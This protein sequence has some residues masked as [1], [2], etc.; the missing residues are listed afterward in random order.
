MVTLSSADN[1]LKSFYLDAMTESLNTKTNPFLAKIERT[2]KYVTG[3]EVCKTMRVGINAGIGA[4][5][6]TGD[7]PAARD[8]QYIQLRTGLKNLYGTIEI[9]DKAIRASA[10]NEGAFVNL[11]NDEME[12]LIKSATFNFG[13]MLFGSG[14]GVLG[15]VSLTFPSG[16]KVTNVQNFATGMY[17]DFVDA[18]EEFQNVRV[19][20]MDYENDALYFKDLDIDEDIIDAELVIHGSQD[21][22]LTGLE[23]IFHASKLYGLSREESYMKPYYSEDF[24]DFTEEK[25]EQVIDA[26]ERNSGDRVNFIIC[27]WD[28]RRMIRNYYQ[29]QGIPVKTMQ[30]EGGF[31]AIEV[32]GIPVVVDKFC[33]KGTMYV[34]NTDYFKLCQ[35][36]DWQWLEA[37]DGK[38][39][40]Q[41][42]GKPVYTATLVKYAELICEKPLAQGKIMGIGEE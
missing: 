21:N 25:L 34:L 6:E 40:K 5:S 3:K 29:A 35:L 1:A 38:I 8:P 9:S 13:R 41:V 36:C 20:H 2:S 28:V 17:I 31:T 42:P 19:E 4:G 16:I 12:S 33:P 27:S 10:N 37:E 26:V 23:A 32:L 22:E 39:L 18:G 24:G 14:D 15:R 11:V 30:I 7:L